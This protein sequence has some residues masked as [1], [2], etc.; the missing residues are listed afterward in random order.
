MYITFNH[1]V[2]EGFMVYIDPGSG[3]IVLQ[4]II[5]TLL[6]GGILLKAFWN[7]IF[8]K[9][10]NSDKDHPDQD[11]DSSSKDEQE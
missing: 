10:T 7:K 1:F 5:A 4:L 3:S 6:G 11:D 2:L 9:N 8:H